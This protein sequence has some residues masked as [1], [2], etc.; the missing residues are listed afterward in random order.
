MNLS[1]K[2][3]LNLVQRPGETEE[4]AQPETMKSIQEGFNRQMYDEISEAIQKAQKS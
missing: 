1:V 3:A 4:A 2:V